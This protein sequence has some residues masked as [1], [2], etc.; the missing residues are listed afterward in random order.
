MA[1]EQVEWVSN[2]EFLR[3]FQRKALAQRIPLSG[4]VD[5]TNRCNLRC[6]HCY[7]GNKGTGKANRKKGLNTSQWIGL[8]DDM[9][10][11]G[12]LFLLMT[13]GEPLL[14][15]DFAEIY[16][17]A[18]HRGLLITVFTNGTLI[19]DNIL[20]LF[21][22]LPPYSVE[23]SL[24]GATEKTYESISGAVGSYEKCLKGIERLLD[25]K[26]NLKL[27]TVLL[28]LNSHEL[29][30]MEQMAKDRG[31]R[32]RFDAAIFP[33]LKG[34]KG[35]LRFRVDPKEAIEKEVADHKRLQQWREHFDRMQALPFSDNLF[36]CGAGL[37][38]F[39]ID[40]YG[41]MKPCLMVQ[42]LQH[43]LSQSTFSEAWDK[44]M[45]QIRTRKL[46]PGNVCARC[47]KSILCGYCP[48]F[49][50]LENG[51]EDVRS[52]YLCALGQHRFEAVQR[53][54]LQEG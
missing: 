45:P 24:Y 46:D 48:A 18:K 3:R 25:L 50:H 37:T 13:G 23:I 27:K 44:V 42:T 22:D 8:I 19:T 29:D 41:R 1:C 26:V 4:S 6:V 47:E 14:R 5:L 20:S 28:T 51:T 17:Y 35:P 9:A 49:F 53:M 16:S 33:S 12:C 36:N 40:V 21:D 11:A 39:H 52:E 43:D 7:I 15:K 10:D 2:Q 54:T 30:S 31:V 34:D 38:A 32:F